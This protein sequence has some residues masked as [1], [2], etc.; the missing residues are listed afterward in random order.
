MADKVS[1]S[2]IQPSMTAKESERIFLSK[3]PDAKSFVPVAK[4]GVLLSDEIERYVNKYKMIHPFTPENLKPAAYKLSVGESYAINGEQRQLSNQ[5]GSNI[6]TIKPFQVAIIQT[7]E[8]L[9]MPNFLIAR[10]NLRVKWAYEGLL[11]VGGAQVDPGFQGFLFCPIYN[12]SDKPVR[13][14]YLDS[15]AVIDFVTTTTPDPKLSKPYKPLSERTRLVLGDYNPLLKSALATMASEKIDTFDVTL[16]QIRTRVDTYTTITFAVLAIL[17]GAIVAIVGNKPALSLGTLFFLPFVTVWAFLF[18]VN[19]GL[20][21]LQARVQS[22]VET[23][24][25]SFGNRL[26]RF[27]GIGVLL[28]FIAVLGIGAVAQVYLNTS[29]NEV[30][31]LRTQSAQLGQGLTD[32]RRQIDSLSA[33]VRKPHS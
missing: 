15:I 5:I 4:T 7:H 25:P 1:G 6:L 32:M 14:E 21:G 17:F 18:L 11:W 20:S 12:L 30:E 2:S 22:R 19:I 8:R 27:S 16:N 23:A 28:L 33:K 3:F 29:L 13:L 26:L 24:G 10:W 9:N 31:S